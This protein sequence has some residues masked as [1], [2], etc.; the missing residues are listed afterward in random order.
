MS[1]CYNRKEQILD[2]AELVRHMQIYAPSSNDYVAGFASLPVGTVEYLS[3]REPVV[4]LKG[5]S[6][7]AAPTAQLTVNH[8][9]AVVLNTSNLFIADVDIGDER[10]NQFAGAT[11]EDEVIEAVKSLQ[12]LD[13]AYP[14]EHLNVTDE[15]YRVY[16]TRQGCRVICTSTCLP[17]TDYASVLLMRFLKTDRQYVNLCGV[18]KCYRARLSPKPW[19]C[20][21][22]PT[23]VCNLIAEIGPKNIHPELAEQLAIHDELTLPVG[24][25]D[26]VL[27]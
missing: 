17:V 24:G 12:R 19:R 15:S 27:A 18:Q 20:S 8:Y 16:R 10:F 11:D 1:S 26:S 14:Y 7:L 25:V 3:N 22:E 21:D 5:L 13:D 23:H 4:N 6:R 2:R 9:N